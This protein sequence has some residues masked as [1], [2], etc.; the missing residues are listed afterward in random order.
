ML[1][2]ISTQFTKA[3]NF[4]TNRFDKQSQ[5]H[6]R[7]IFGK[8]VNW[9]KRMDV[10]MKVANLKPSDFI[11]LLSFLRNF[12]TACDGNGIHEGT[13]MW[14]FQNLM[15]DPAKAALPNRVCGS[16]EDDTHQAHKE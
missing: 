14:L 11:A 7:R 4:N 9:V 16:K 8:I 3:L 10:Q 2:P 6:D 1:E 15:K 5:K 13:D 12:K